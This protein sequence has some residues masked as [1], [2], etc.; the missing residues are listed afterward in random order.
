MVPGDCGLLQLL[1][2]SE[3]QGGKQKKSFQKVDARPGSPRGSALCASSGRP[4]Q[5]PCLSCP[6]DLCQ[7]WRTMPGKRRKQSL[8][9]PGHK[10][11]P[12]QIRERTDI[13]HTPH[14]WQA[15][16]SPWAS[17]ALSWGGGE[18]EHAPSA[19]TCGPQCCQTRDREFLP[20]QKGPGV[21][22][23]EGTRHCLRDSGLRCNPC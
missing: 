3:S 12:A 22:K 6:G 15:E 14:L 5:G 1:C 11:W 20:P 4:R 18:G 23:E 7:A 8:P 21:K 10:S 9:G 16:H 17:S 19:L 13:P 2:S